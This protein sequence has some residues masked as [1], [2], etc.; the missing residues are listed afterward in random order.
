MTARWRE[1]GA[2]PGTVPSHSTWMR[3]KGHIDAAS[4]VQANTQNARKI[5]ISDL[6]TNPDILNLNKNNTSLMLVERFLF[7]DNF[8][9]LLKL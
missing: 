8:R 2:S 4:Q 5:L 3:Q 1:A 9:D 7:K 6:F